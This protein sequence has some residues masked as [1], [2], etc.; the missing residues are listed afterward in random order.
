M[1]SN[2]AAGVAHLQAQLADITRNNE[3]AIIMGF[4]GAGLP[5][6]IRAP[7]PIGIEGSMGRAAELIAASGM[8]VELAK[9]TH[10]LCGRSVYQAIADGY[11]ARILNA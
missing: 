5:E 2:T 4:I 1:H 8:T 7:K 6:M 11:Q 3:K 9:A 10:L